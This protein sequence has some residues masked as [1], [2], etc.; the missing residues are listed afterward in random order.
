MNIYYIYA[1]IRSSD[2]TPYYIGKGK[3]K[4][5]F[6]THRNKKIPVPKDRSKIIIMES[7]LTEIGALALERR[8]I[9]WWGRKD[10]GTGILRNMTDGG[11]GVC[12]LTPWNKGIPRTEDVK[13]RIS[14]TKKQRAK[15]ISEEHRSNLSKSRKGKRPFQSKSHSTLTKQKMRN[16]KIGE[17]NHMFGKTHSEKTKQK[18]RERWI[19]RKLMIASTSPQQP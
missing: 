5:V 10:I 8:Y 19:K 4:R 16:K 3:G 9:R 17:Q 7:G 12:G 6:E 18:M 13:R 15:P 2:G 11:D 14:A 1:Y